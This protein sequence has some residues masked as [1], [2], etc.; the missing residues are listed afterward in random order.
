M[1]TSVSLVVV[2]SKATLIRSHLTWYEDEGPVHR[3]K[4][5]PWT[6]VLDKHTDGLV[7]A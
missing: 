6:K 2:V 4:D 3:G 7:S 1:T 5:V